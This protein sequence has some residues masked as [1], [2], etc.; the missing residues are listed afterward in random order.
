MTFRELS[1]EEFNKFAKNYTKK[2]IYQTKEYGDF[3]ELEG[4]KSLY[5][6]L[7]D[8]VDIVAACLV[9]Y[10]G[11]TLKYG[12]I[13]KGIMIDYSDYELLSKFTSELKRYLSR[14]DI[15]AFKMNPLIVKN[16][17]DK[18]YNLIDSNKEYETLVSNLTR[19]GYIHLGHNK[20]FEATQPRFEAVVDL[21]EDKYTLFANMTKQFRTKAR[22]AENR[23]VRIYKGSKEELEEIYNN[24]NLK[25]HPLSW[26]Q[27]LL[28]A[29]NNDIEIYYAKLNMNIYLKLCQ[30]DLI[31]HE[32]YNSY[33]NQQ[34]INSR[35]LNDTKTIDKKMESDI[36][37]SESRKKLDDALR[38]TSNKQDSL[39]LCLVVAIKDS[40]GV[41]LVD[42]S[43]DK[44]NTKF[45]ASHLLIWKL[46]EHY[47]EIGYTYLNIGGMTINEYENKYQGLN[48][49]KLGFGSNVY[50][51]TGDYEC[52]TNYPKYL[53]YSKSGS[54]F[55]K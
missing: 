29:Y 26:Y 41:T 16:R 49:Y 6:G 22:S 52:I 13:P 4:Y 27:H 24:L 53:L 32:K 23:G 50:E 25:R 54:L 47:Q 10:K 15:V 30:E 19:C 39:I 36:K 55:K 17:F 18:K 40:N 38:L 37:L 42:I 8:N 51:F 9:I 21:K 7:V 14:K 44:T 1:I 46:M 31:N 2:S 5:L 12:Y 3:S 48:N 43:Y 45:N 20:Y 33:L 34:V 28:E 11:S 35:G